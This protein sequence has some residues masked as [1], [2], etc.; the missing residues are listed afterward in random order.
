MNPENQAESDQQR[1]QAFLDQEGAS[2]PGEID[3][4]EPL[5]GASFDVTGPSGPVPGVTLLLKTIER[6]PE[7][8]GRN[9]SIRRQPYCLL[10]TGPADQPIRPG[11]YK[12][13]PQSVSPDKAF[14]AHLNLYGL[15]EGQE[16]SYEVVVN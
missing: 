6:L 10:F 15:E 1:D 9:Q 12:L 5:V 14:V 11:L 13:T 2:G 3:D 4:V 7:Y 8:T 16:A